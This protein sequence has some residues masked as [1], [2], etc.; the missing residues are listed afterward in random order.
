VGLLNVLEERDVQIRGF[1]IRLPLDVLL[2]ATANPEDY[3]NRGRIITPLKDR[4]GAQI[5][6][7]YPPDTETEMAIVAQEAEPPPTGPGIPAVSVPPFMA[8]IVAELSQLARQSPQLNQHSGVSVRLSIAN[9]ETLAANALRRSLRL[10]EA[11]AVPRLSDLPALV[12]STQG[13]VEIE[14]LE[15]GREERILH[16]LLAAAVLAVFRRRVAS[17][18]AATVATAFE[19]STV[20]HTGDDLPASAYADALRAVPALGDAVRGLID[21]EAPGMVAAATEL[22]LEGLHLSKRL[23]KDAAGDRATYRGRR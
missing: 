1:T 13:K 10:G 7:H 23:N 16:A 19:G 8:E 9:Q 2:V 4:F 12:A 17:Q 11:E 3:T 5:R 14:A 21:G 6:T 18:Q 22:V 15:E 20:V